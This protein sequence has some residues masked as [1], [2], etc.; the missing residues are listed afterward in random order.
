MMI[1]GRINGAFDGASVD[2]S[3]PGDR[4]GT[5]PLNDVSNLPDCE[6]MII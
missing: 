6:M 1:S 3:N 4:Y 2:K 5:A